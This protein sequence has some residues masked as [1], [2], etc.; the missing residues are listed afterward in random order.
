LENV[1][2]FFFS[3]PENDRKIISMYYKID[4]MTIYIDIIFLENL[5]MNYI[6]LL[7][8][9][10]IVKS[11]INLMR[12]FLSSTI[13]GTYAVLLYIQNFWILSDWIFKILLSLLMIYIAF[14]AKKIKIFLKELLIFYLV[15]F[16]FGGVALALAYL[17][18][19]GAVFNKYPIKLI[20]VG[21]IIRGNNNNCS[22]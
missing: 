5:L 2:K 1:D 16:T 3:R 18:N 4:A 20:A 19:S 14:N 21:G 13:G 15:S 6:I 8:T 17:M 7:C 10:I 12:L 22:I 11:K 9:G